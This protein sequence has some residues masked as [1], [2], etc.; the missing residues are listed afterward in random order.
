MRR[1]RYRQLQ[2]SLYITGQKAP[3]IAC[4]DEEGEYRYTHILVLL[5][6]MSITVV[7]GLKDPRGH[8][9]LWLPQL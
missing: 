3:F 5:T 8:H 9:R 7:I 4:R 2:S 1:R 6:D